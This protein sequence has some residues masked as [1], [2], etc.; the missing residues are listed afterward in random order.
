M[1]VGV[2]DHYKESGQGV[3]DR[4]SDAMAKLRLCQ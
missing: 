2:S 3:F 4:S 1:T